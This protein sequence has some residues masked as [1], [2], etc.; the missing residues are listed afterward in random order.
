MVNVY[1]LKVGKWLNNAGGI[2]RWGA[3]ILLMVVAAVA[4]WRFGSATPIGLRDLRPGLQFKDLVFWSVI[5][6]A[7][8]GPESIALMSGE[9][10]APRRTI[11]LALTIAA[12]VIA[13]IY[14]VGTL[15]VL[16]PRA[17]RMRR[18]ASCKRS[19][20]VTRA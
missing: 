12:P 10:V 13:V 15:A 18:P 2:A 16:V 5:A 1:G 4:L 3:S 14:V 11:P 6:F 8:T 7:W 20:T 19:R 17:T 9:I